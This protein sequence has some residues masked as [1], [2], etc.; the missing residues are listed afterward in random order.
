MNTVLAGLDVGAKTL[1][2]AIRKN[3]K[4]QKPRDFGN[5]ATAHAALI[6]ALRH[7][8]VA[9]VCVEATGVYHLDVAVALHDAGGFEVMVVN[10]K[11][12][13]RFAEAMMSRTKTDPVDA[14]LLAEFA[15]RMPFVPWVRPADEVLAVRAFG[16]YLAGLT[17]QRTQ[18]KN[19]LHAWQ[20]SNTTPGAI[21]TAVSG[22][23]QDLDI[24]IELI[25]AQALQL[26]LD[27]PALYRPYELLVS[28]K[29]IAQASAIALL[30]ELRVLPEDMTA[31]QWVAM[32]GLDPRHYQSGSS[33][34]KKPRI[35]KAG[36]RYLRGALYMPALSATRHDPHLRGFYQHLVEHRGLKK[37]QAVCAVMRKL[38][39]ALH[40]ML[41]THTCFDGSR[42]FA[43]PPEA[44][45]PAEA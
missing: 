3:G 5:D 35:S 43:L 16:R 13:R 45:A 30:G 32:A 10:P 7:A 23:I 28:V 40:A 4:I 18:L 36:N 24:Q 44:I 33:V 42:L 26:I 8:H 12:A 1:T 22:Q 9:R 17:K 6:Q 34:N 11:A 37:L 14:A 15:A 29:G 41:S 19:Q 31:R 38:L 25:R 20:Q 21:V 39:T 27:H 2:L